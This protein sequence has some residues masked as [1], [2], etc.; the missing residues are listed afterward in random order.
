M[1]FVTNPASRYRMPIMFGPAPG[2]R[3]HPDGRMWTPE[4]GGG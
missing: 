3:Q 2:P 4:E 1:A